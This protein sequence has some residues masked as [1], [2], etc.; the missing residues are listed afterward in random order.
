M[1]S[2]LRRAFGLPLPAL[3]LQAATA[4]GAMALHPMAPCL[5]LDAC[6]RVS[7]NE[8]LAVKDLFV[9]SFVCS[10]DEEEE[11]YPGLPGSP[12]SVAVWQFRFSI[13]P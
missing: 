3:H 9:A 13:L 10:H 11:H 6:A 8:S 2:E 1:K 4:P 12:I 7:V 5:Q